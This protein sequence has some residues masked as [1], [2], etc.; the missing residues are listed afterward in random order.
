ML[1]GL[2]GHLILQLIAINV[3]IA[4]ERH[5]SFVGLLLR[6]QIASELGKLQIEAVVCA[7]EC[8]HCFLRGKITSR[9]SVRR[10]M[11]KN[12]N[13]R[14]TC[15]S[16]GP[17]SFRWRTVLNSSYDDVSSVVIAEV[18]STGTGQLTLESPSF[19]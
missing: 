3:K 1:L 5:K 15:Y 16:Y 14:C 17:T 6:L 4:N 11:G 9:K 12:P 7:L 13:P 19:F 8:R 18:V 2:V 10:G